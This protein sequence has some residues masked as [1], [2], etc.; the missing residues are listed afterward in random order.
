[1]PLRQLDLDRQPFAN[2]RVFGAAGAYCQLLGTASFAVDPR[3]P[4]NARIVDLDL[5]PRD[6]S[7][8]VR[9]SADVRI[10]MP[11]DPGRGNR[12]LVLDV[13]NRGNP[14]AIRNTDLGVPR[15]PE[16]DSQGWLLQQGYTIVSCGW[17]HNVP[18]GTPRLGLRAP[19]A[20]RNGEP[21]TGQ[22][23][24]IVQVNTPTD[25]I[26]VADEPSPVEHVAYPVADL[27]SPNDTLAELD[28]PLGPRRLIPRERWRFDADRSHVTF[29]D[30][31]VPGKIYEVIY[32]A[33]GA[34]VTGIGFLALRDTVA[35]LRSASASDG[36]PCAGTLDFAIA[37]G[38]SQTGRLLRH[39][40]YL[41]MY[42]D[43]DGQLLLDGVLALIAGPLR[44]EANWRFGQP[45]FIGSDSPGFAPPFLDEPVP[46]DGP[47]PKVIHINTSAEYV[48][49]D[50]ALIHT[51]A[52]GQADADIPDDVRIYHLAGTHHGGG[53]LP[54]DNRVFSSVATYY[55]NSID[56][57]PLVRAAFANLD[58]WAT[59]NV[60]PPPSAYPRLSDGTL[61]PRAA[62][63]SSVAELPGPGIPPRRL[64]PTQHLDYGPDAAHGI[65][66]FPAVDGGSYPDGVP[67]V[68]TDGNERSGVRHPDVAVP[69]ATYTGW[70][71]RHP[72]I[73]GSMMNLLLNGATIPF[74]PTRALRAAW[75]DARP[76]IEERYP[77]RESY[78]SQVR[79]AATSLAAARYLLESDIDEIL[80]TSARRCDEFIQLQSPLP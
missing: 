51:T 11:E 20:T 54:L 77:S 66:S 69:L 46:A 61:V 76:S 70:N 80:A 21:L 4:V 65:A 5:A 26:G 73:G 18:P 8:M 32:T 13:V 56:Y 15:T 10:L 48:N 40:L 79:A 35:F 38:G 63:V 67:A 22:V 3:H 29:D 33:R 64:Y 49:L 31:F 62:L 24:A 6:A 45:S 19:E 2:G 71:P 53:A 9:F 47:R 50:V 36:N 12:R 75:R 1:M 39:L 60:V 43:E 59:R 16:P 78:L 68:D 57:R 34:P 28:Y 23:R 42:A 30:G 74:A 25:R 55:N 41:G 52:D 44:T 14:V 37:F 7:G 27:A 72:S 58:A 17:Q